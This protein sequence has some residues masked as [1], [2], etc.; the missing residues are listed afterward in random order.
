MI[1]QL[2]IRTLLRSDQVCLTDICSGGIKGRYKPNFELH[3][4]FKTRSWLKDYPSFAYTALKGAEYHLQSMSDIFTQSF[5]AQG[6]ERKR[7]VD[8]QEE[9]SRSEWLKMNWHLR[10]VFWELVSVWDITLRWCNE[11]FEL[12]EESAPTKQKSGNLRWSQMR[13]CRPA[14]G[15]ETDWE[16]KRRIIDDVWESL[17]FLRLEP[18]GTQ[19]IRSL[20]RRK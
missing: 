7:P 11:Y 19:L 6:S 2:E 15:K 18:I 8:F 12:R 3:P 4:T 1:H 10:G 9:E 14:E 16:L 13:D 5:I 17:W 20:S